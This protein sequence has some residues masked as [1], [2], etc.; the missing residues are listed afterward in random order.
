MSNSRTTVSGERYTKSNM[1]NMTAAVVTVIL[2]KDLSPL[3]CMSA[4]SAA[5]PVT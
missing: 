3:C 4:T 5:V 2:A 1:M